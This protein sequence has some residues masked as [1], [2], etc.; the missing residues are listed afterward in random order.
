MRPLRWLACVVLVL[1]CWGHLPGDNHYYDQ[2]NL[3]IFLAATKAGID[4]QQFRAQLE[5]ENS[6]AD[7]KAESSVGAVGCGQFMPKTW[8]WLAETYE[9]EHWRITSCVDSIFMSA[10][11]M[12]YLMDR[13]ESFG[14]KVEE[15][16]ECALIAYNHGE[17]KLKAILE[18]IGGFALDTVSLFVPE[19]TR[20]YLAKIAGGARWFKRRV[21]RR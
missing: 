21:L 19:E 13:C 15:R 18:D 20:A 3:V 5:T 8:D 17:G 7:P 1:T 6:R 2:Y 9:I 14:V 4:P 10:L 12:R 16:W 11:Y